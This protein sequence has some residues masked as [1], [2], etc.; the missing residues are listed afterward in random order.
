MDDTQDG[1][2]DG[3]GKSRSRSADDY[4]KVSDLADLLLPLTDSKKMDWM[5]PDYVKISRA[6]GPDRERLHV[7]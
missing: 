3:S 6:Q 7:C 2:D 1:E 4:F 5:I